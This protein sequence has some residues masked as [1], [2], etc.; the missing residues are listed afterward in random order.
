MM[1]AAAPSVGG[2]RIAPMPDAA[3]IPPPSSL[4]YP[5]LRSSGQATLPSVTVV[6]TPEPETVPSRKPA[7]A[8]V[9]PGPVR[10]RPNA[11][12][13]MSMK[14]RAAPLNSSTAP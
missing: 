1:K 2:L 13:E 11:A 14:K 3:M 12:N 4:G 7:S 10:L 5:A 8:D 9:R 6:A